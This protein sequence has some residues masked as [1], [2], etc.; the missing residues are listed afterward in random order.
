MYVG[1]SWTPKQIRWYRWIKQSLYWWYPC[2]IKYEEGKES[3]VYVAE[4]DFTN[5]ETSVFITLPEFCEGNFGEF[6]WLQWKLDFI[7]N[8][9]VFGIKESDAKYVMLISKHLIV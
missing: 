6:H 3:G 9:Y 4:M 2:K 7:V 5:S 8:M 1:P